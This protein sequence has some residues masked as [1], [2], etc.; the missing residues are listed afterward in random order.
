[1]KLWSILTAQKWKYHI[2]YILKTYQIYYIK[3]L[4]KITLK[5]L[6]H[7][8]CKAVF[9]GKYVALNMVSKRKKG[10]NSKWSIHLNKWQEEQ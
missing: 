9:R 6:S 10:K 2:N 7:M 3:I 5:D 4:Q 1:M 8:T